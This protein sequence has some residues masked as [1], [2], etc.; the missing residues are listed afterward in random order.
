M[1]EPEKKEDKG[2]STSAQN[3]GPSPF[4]NSSPSPF[5]APIGGGGF[6]QSAFAKGFA[7]AAPP[8]GAR[9]T[10]FASPS[11]QPPPAK[12]KAF[13]TISDDE[14]EGDEEAE[15]ETPIKGFEEEKMDERFSK[16]ESK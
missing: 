13:G 1:P 8:A 14:E 5:A 6:A 7:S 9:L 10:S 16:K 3:L 11:V 4:S 15:E 12:A 2:T